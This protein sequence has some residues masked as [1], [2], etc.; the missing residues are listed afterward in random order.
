MS[1]KKR[2]DDDELRA[3]STIGAEGVAAAYKVKVGTA[4]TWLA[5][6]NAP[7][8]DRKRAAIRRERMTRDEA[9]DGADAVL[10]ELLAIG[11]DSD[12]FAGSPKD[13]GIQARIL[14]ETHTRLLDA[15]GHTRDAVRQP[16][17]S[18]LLERVRAATESA[19]KAQTVH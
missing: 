10:R 18:E 19:E 16:D 11:L 17:R 2:P 14:A 12:F 3:I 9:A 13:R 1:R 7:E 4:R 5:E 15:Q 6:I 8:R